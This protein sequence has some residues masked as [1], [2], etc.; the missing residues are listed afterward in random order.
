MAS[1]FPVSDLVDIFNT[2]EQ[3][4]LV[5]NANDSYFDLSSLTSLP[6]S[7]TLSKIEP[8]SEESPTSESTV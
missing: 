6:Q 8:V 1:Q 4:V 2:S 3:A 7:V 5:P